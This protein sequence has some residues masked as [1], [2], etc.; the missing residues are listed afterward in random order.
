MVRGLMSGMLVAAMALGVP[1]AGLAKPAVSVA[2][3]SIASGTPL[4]VATDT[5]RSVITAMVDIGTLRQV[6]DALQVTINWPYAPASEGPDNADQERIICSPSH[7][8]SYPVTLGKVGAHGTYHV[9]HTYD[10]AKQR[11]I[12]E[13]ED[14]QMAAMG[15]I[16]PSYGDD[17]RS[18]ACWAAARKCAGE[19]FTWPPPPNETPL[20]KSPRAVAMND[21]YNRQFRPSCTLK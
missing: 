12:A 20:V 3:S 18:L 15:G 16:P 17:P 9:A 6:G 10:V 2:A 1:R 4:W 8:I 14:R 21:A 19:K 13:R 7:A 11:R 5:K